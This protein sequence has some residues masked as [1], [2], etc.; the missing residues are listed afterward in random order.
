MPS[1]RQSG[2]IPNAVAQLQEERRWLIL[3]RLLFAA[4]CLS[5]FGL[6]A[7]ALPSLAFGT[8]VDEPGAA[9]VLVVVF[10][11]AAAGF[12]FASWAVWRPVLQQEPLSELFTLLFGGQKLVRT[13]AQFQHR[14]AV[15]CDRAKADSERE[16]M[17]IVVRTPDD[18]AEPR[19]KLS[20]GEPG[21]ATLVVRGSARTDDIVAE[22]RPNEVWLLA[23]GV[24]QDL[25]QS[26]V[27]R[28]AST[29]TDKIGS[30]AQ[31]GAAAFGDDGTKPETLFDVAYSR[32]AEL[33]RLERARHAA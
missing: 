10:S 5:W 33:S 12:T 4:A 6:L 27:A 13:P 23:Q 17:L 9:T 18:A 32:M 28:L 21:L 7:W 15:E 25:R 19:R 20:S 30:S 8:S 22:S 3:A 14:L 29:L 11:V 26:V 1:G 31:L 2:T 24:A 16:F